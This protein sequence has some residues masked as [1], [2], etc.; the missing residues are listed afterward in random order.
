M[1]EQPERASIRWP[2]GFEGGILHRLDTSTSGAVALAR[3]PDELLAI[4][5]LFREQRLVKRYLLRVARRSSWSENRCDKPIAHDPR[6]KGRM[7][8]QRGHN[9]PHRGRWMEAHSRFYAI[10]GDLYGAE[11]TTGVTHQIRV[12]AA[13]LGVPLLGDRRYGGGVAPEGSGVEF[14]LHHEGFEGPGCLRTEP[15][16]APAWAQR[17]ESSIVSG[18]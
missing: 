12:H 8:V 11:I 15:V 16:R 10:R 4:R 6:H 1:R 9:T 13:F 14:F 7:I 18:A 2:E 17:P 3:D 5:A